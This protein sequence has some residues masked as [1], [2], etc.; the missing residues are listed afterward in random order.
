MNANL[1]VKISGDEKTINKRLAILFK[2]SNFLNKVFKFLRFK[3]SFCKITHVALSCDGENCSNEIDI[4]QKTISINSIKEIR[5]NAKKQG[6]INID[7]KD[8][9]PECYKNFVI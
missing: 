4:T 5:E 2:I 6:W 8:Y 1:D 7:G 9:C 3:K